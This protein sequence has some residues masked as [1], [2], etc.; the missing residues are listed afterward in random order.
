MLQKYKIETPKI[1]KNKFFNKK[2]IVAFH[3]RNAP[4]D[5]HKWIH[6]LALQK[7]N[8]LLI[9]PIVSQF[10]KGEFTEEAILHTYKIYIRNKNKL[11]KKCRKK[12]FLSSLHLFPKYGGPREALLHALIRKNYGC[13]HFLVGRDHAGISNYYKKYASQKIC[14]KFEKQLGIKIIKFKSPGCCSK[15]NKIVNKKC[16]FFDCKISDING[17]LIRK[18]IKQKK[19]K[20]I[21]FFDKSLLKGLSKK[22]L[23]I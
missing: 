17:S 10:R 4:H 2:E 19:Y 7:Y 22:K 8:Y 15:C 9:Q 21:K 12:I 16:T 1:I 3:T 20:N 5:G 13:T 11:L 18:K 23:I 6:D 14:K